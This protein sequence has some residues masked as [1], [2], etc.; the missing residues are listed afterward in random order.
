M[1]DLGENE[2]LKSFRAH[3]A[4]LQ[5]QEE[6]VENIIKMIQEEFNFENEEESSEKSRD[7]G[8]E[9]SGSNNN[10]NEDNIVKEEEK[11]ESLK[12]N[13][14]DSND[15]GDE[16]LTEINLTDEDEKQAYEDLIEFIEKAIEF[17]ANALDLSKKNLR[18]IPFKLTDL[19]NLEV[20]SVKI[21]HLIR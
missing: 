6:Q 5:S 20:C 18:K 17:G 16:Y 12:S 14:E 10:S 2:L 19:K 15:L 8:F 21:S 3:D 9:D 11:Y 13:Q 1:V 4:D 7:T